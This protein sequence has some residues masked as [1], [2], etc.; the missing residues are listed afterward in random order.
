[1]R[2]NNNKEHP[3]EIDEESAGQSRGEAHV[4]KVPST[5]S[6]VPTDA[7]GGTHQYLTQHRGDDG[8]R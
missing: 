8:E 6:S 4:R 3:A 2:R 7:G 5:R 1:M